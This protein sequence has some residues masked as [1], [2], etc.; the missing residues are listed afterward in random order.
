MRRFIGVSICLMLSAIAVHASSGAKAYKYYHRG[1]FISV[2]FAA[3]MTFN[4]G[5]DIPVYT[6]N[7]VN[8]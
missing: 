5:N 4:E 6:K 1:V 3:G 7:I 8:N 2:D